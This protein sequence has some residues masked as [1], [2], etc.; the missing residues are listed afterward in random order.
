MQIVD[1]A[2]FAVH[3]EARRVEAA[4]LALALLELGYRD[5]RVATALADGRGLNYSLGGTMDAAPEDG[6]GRSYKVKLSSALA[7][8][9]GLPGVLR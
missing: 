6:G 7:P 4:T 3:D 1:P 8:V 5:A 2:R 9:P